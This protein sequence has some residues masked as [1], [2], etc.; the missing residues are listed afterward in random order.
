MEDLKKL[1]LENGYDFETVVVNFFSDLKDFYKNHSDVEVD[2]RLHIND[3]K[4][5]VIEIKAE[6]G[7]VYKLNVSGNSIKTTIAEI[8]KLISNKF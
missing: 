7:Y 4:E 1:G 6:N 3:N 8:T 2:F 5:Q